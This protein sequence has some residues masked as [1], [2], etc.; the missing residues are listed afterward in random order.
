[1]RY[2]DSMPDNEEGS[3]VDVLTVSIDEVQEDLIRIGTD[4]NETGRSVVVM[5]DGTPWLE[6]VP[7]C[8]EG[9]FD[10]LP[11]ETIEA[12]EEA[13]AVRTHSQHLRFKS[14]EDFF[15]HLGL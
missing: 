7:L 6:M 5:K 4:C 13:E 9:S 14:A 10:Q 15:S 12:I 1:M 11:Q 3:T 2:A 8:H